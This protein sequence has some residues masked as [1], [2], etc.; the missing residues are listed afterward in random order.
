MDSVSLDLN[1]LKIFIRNVSSKARY[2]LG[3]LL[4]ATPKL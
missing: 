2:D 3:L 1:R 4:G